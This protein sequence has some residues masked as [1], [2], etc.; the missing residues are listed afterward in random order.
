MGFDD[1]VDDAIIADTDMGY[2]SEGTVQGPPKIEQDKA[3]TFM[4]LA[5]ACLV[6]FDYAPIFL[7]LW[8]Y[9]E[10]LG[11]NY[12]LYSCAS[13]MYGLARIPVAPLLSI[14]ADYYTLRAPLLLCIVAFLMA[15]LLYVS[16]SSLANTW[17]AV[18]FVFVA[19]FLSGVGGSS[20]PV[21]MT[22]L[23][24][25]ST[26]EERVQYFNQ[27]RISQFLG[28]TVGPIVATVCLFI[29]PGMVWVFWMNAATIP[30]L[31]TC[32][33]AFVLLA[34][35]AIF[36]KE[37]KRDDHKI[38]LLLIHK[39]AEFRDAMCLN[40]SFL[41]GLFALSLLS[42]QLIPIATTVFHI[43]YLDFRW[44][45]LAYISFFVGFVISAVL[46]KLTINKFP[47][48]TDQNF[49]VYSL[50]FIALGWFGFIQWTT[51][52]PIWV[53]FVA[54]T[55]I[56]M[57]WGLFMVSHRAVYAR[58]TEPSGFLTSFMALLSIGGSIAMV[59]APLFEAVTLDI[60]PNYDDEDLLSECQS[61]GYGE[62]PDC[63]DAGNGIYCCC[64]MTGL[65]VVAVAAVIVLVGS[66]IF[67]LFLVKKLGVGNLPEA[68]L[69]N[70]E[71]GK[72]ILDNVE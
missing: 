45:W 4:V 39:S 37:P 18:A 1:S 8:P 47:G 6:S 58:V 59:I 56:F 40:V 42:F 53:Y 35:T 63:C 19:R 41:C 38:K 13:A 50:L 66:T 27:F 57:G 16:A 7:T 64:K 68:E 60:V 70:D 28:N 20:V 29:P 44:V 10:W 30:A 72:Y 48:F 25:I 65:T 46:T 9:M 32:S 3:T 24:V 43:A 26:P 69:S 22:Y 54:S 52:L 17:W 11:G 62:A 2:I 36:F 61:M 15:N 51:Y 5:V 33:F 67:Q 14:A 31:L 21:V 71:E 49:M 23:S 34:P 55:L 12:F